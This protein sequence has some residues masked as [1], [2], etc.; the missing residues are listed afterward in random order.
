MSFVIKKKK[1]KK[2]KAIISLF[3]NEVIS[4]R[5]TEPNKHNNKTKQNKIKRKMPAASKAI[6]SLFPNEVISRRQTEPIKHNNKIKQDKTK[7]KMPAANNDKIP[8][9]TEQHQKYQ[10]RT[11]RGKY[12]WR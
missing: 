10:L 7:R 2:G 6:I 9:K 3:P 8:K 5:Q 11:F 4:R 1:K 12:C